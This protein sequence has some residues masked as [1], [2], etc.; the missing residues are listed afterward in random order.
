[1]TTVAIPIFLS[2]LRLLPWPATVTSFVYAHIIN[3]PAFGKVHSTPV[4]GLGYIPTR[5]QALFIAFLWF[6]N[7][8]FCCIDYTVYQPNAWGPDQLLCYIANRAGHLSFVNLSLT[9]LFALRNNPLLWLTSWSHSTFLLLHRWIAVICVIQAAVHSVL[10]VDKYIDVISQQMVRSD[11]QWGIVAMLCF[12]FILPL[13]VL[14]LRQKLYSF[15]LASHIL[16][17]LLAVVGC[18]LHVTYRYEWQWGFEMWLLMA[19][20]FWAFERLLARP[21]RIWQAG[22]RRAFVT[23]VD[24][25]YLQVVI[26]GVELHGHA[27]FYFPTIT[28][29]IWESNPF[30]VIP[31]IGRLPTPLSIASSSDIEEMHGEYKLPAIIGERSIFFGY[32]AD[33]LMLFMRRRGGVTRRLAKYA[34]SPN[35]VMVWIEGSYGSHTS[36]VSPEPIRTTLEYPSTLFIAGGVGITAMVPHILHTRDASPSRAA[37]KLI[38]ASRSQALVD[39]VRMLFGVEETA[40]KIERWGDC[41]VVTA[42]GRRINLKQV[43]ADEASAGPTTV[44]VCGPTEM[45]DEARMVV[46]DL[47]KNGNKIRLIEESYV[48]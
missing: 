10:Y 33:G 8:L 27:Y 20:S 45:M 3:P 24:D 5:G 48:W 31:T 29:R 26:P 38:W 9:F 7:I 41:D 42:V 6:I 43:I 34:D 44:V 30:S 46:V 19:M 28:W 4:L 16:L 40:E 17:A 18:V 11:W 25:N 15:F 1:M 22:S 36:I 39:R 23:I 35:G 37:Y 47:C 13:S 14:K 21:F 12:L 32:S 2:C